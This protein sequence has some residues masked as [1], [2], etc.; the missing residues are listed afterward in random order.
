MDRG[1]L[2]ARCHR[3]D[4]AGQA[5]TV[6]GGPDV[7]T[8]ARWRVL[9]APIAVSVAVGVLVGIVWALLAPAE[10]FVVVAPGRGA[11]LTGES[12][13]RFDALA[14]A[15]CAAI[16]AGIVLPVAVW[17]WTAARGPLQF[18]GIL[19]GSILGSGAMLGVGIAVARWVHPRPDDPATGS[20]V[21]VAPGFETPLL[22]V[23]QP[24]V[25]SLVVLLL[26]AMNPHDNLRFTPLDHDGDPD[27]SEGSGDPAGTSE[28]DFLLERDRA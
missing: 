16:A 12:L 20:V 2:P 14:M 22:L 18:A 19:I 5:L 28:G 13:H 21:A 25:A 8:T 9:G 26:V 23:V 10:R 27:G 24:L 4:V 3:F 15:A 7:P 11:A 1:M 6:T 17:A